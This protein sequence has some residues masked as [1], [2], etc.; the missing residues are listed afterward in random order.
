MKEVKRKM[1]PAQLFLLLSSR[2]PGGDQSFEIDSKAKV[3][4]LEISKV[5]NLIP[6]GL[7][8]LERFENVRQIHGVLLKLTSNL[9]IFNTRSQ[10]LSSSFFDL[11]C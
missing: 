11:F 2:F 9:T 10:Q 3:E 1:N 4:L 8:F 6:N 7:E 5:L